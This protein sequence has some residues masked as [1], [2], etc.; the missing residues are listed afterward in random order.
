[1]AVVNPARSEAPRLARRVPLADAVAG[2]E[3]QIPDAGISS[4]ASAGGG[5]DLELLVEVRKDAE[6]CQLLGHAVDED[7]GHRPDGELTVHRA[8]VVRGAGELRLGPPDELPVV[9]R[10]R[11]TGGDGAS[12]RR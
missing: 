7:G 5:G 12:V 10:E 6:E 1:M 2:K 3:G 4:R 8:R 9:N 11:G